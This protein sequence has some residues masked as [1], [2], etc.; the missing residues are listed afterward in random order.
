MPSPIPLKQFRSVGGFWGRYQ[1]E[2]AAKGLIHQWTQ[3]VTTGRLQNFLDVAEGKSGTHRGIRF[4]DSDLYKWLEAAAYSQVLNPNSETKAAMELAIQAIVNAQAEDGYIFTLVQLNKPDWKWK[5]L[6]HMHEMYCIGHLVEACIALNQ[7]GDSRL[8]PVAIKAV[9]CITDTFGPGT[10][11]GSCGHPE[12][13]L[14]LYRLWHETGHKKYAELSDWMIDCRGQRPSPFETEFETPETNIIVPK[15]HWLEFKD[16]KY[17]GS[18]LQDDKPIRDQ[19]TIVGHSVRAAYLYSA[20]QLSAARRK[21][22]E[23]QSALNRIWTNLTER[24]MYITGGIGSTGDGEGFT[25]DFDLPNL[26]AYAETCAGIA[27]AMW[28]RRSFEANPSTDPLDVLERVIFN[29]VLSGIAQD[30]TR[31]FYD[32][33]LESRANTERQPWFG[34]ACCPPN[35]ARLI[36]SITDYALQADNKTLYIA[37]PIE[38]E[39]TLENGLK[40]GIK[41]Q[42]PH[43]GEAQITVKATKPTRYRLAIRIPDWAEEV[44]TTLPGAQPAEYEEGFAVFDEVWEGERTLNVEFEMEPRI[45]ASSSKVL[46]NLGRVAIQ[47]G[48]SVYCAESLSEDGAPQRATLDLSEEIQLGSART[49]AGAPTLEVEALLQLDDDGPLYDYNQEPKFAQTTLKLIPYREWNA[50]EKSF[51]QVW[52]RS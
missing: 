39:F 43:K 28:A 21:D 33:P 7:M 32:N 17:D 37:F 23:L 42:Y 2:L 10:R 5:N 29:G 38:C 31:Y 13:E 6:V 20:A 19:D 34:C 8:M 41:T 26:N 15:A 12:I 11:V 16:G 14:A 46:D 36:A 52:L 30:T 45:V 27:L 40:V 9:D 22:Q 35:I 18:Y 4:D 25:A 24:R 50:S 47:Y 1:T 44:T 49:K 3:I 48:P 51:M